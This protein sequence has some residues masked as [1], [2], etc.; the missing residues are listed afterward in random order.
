MFRKLT[1]AFVAAAAL[2]TAAMAP[3]TA[4]AWGWGHGGWHGGWHHGWGGGWGYRGWGYRAYGGGPGWCYY[5][6]YRCG[7]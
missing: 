2:G 7:Y 5:H 3:T 1:I 4:S 6:P